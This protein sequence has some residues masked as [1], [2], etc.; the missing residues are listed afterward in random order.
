MNEFDH[1]V[2]NADVAGAIEELAARRS[3]RRPA[4]GPRG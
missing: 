3:P 1:V 2:V 4:Q